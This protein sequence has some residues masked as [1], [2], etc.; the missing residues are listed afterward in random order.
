MTYAPR[1]HADEEIDL[2]PL[3]GSRLI[4]PKYP[5][6]PALLKPDGG[7]GLATPP[8]MKK[9]QTCLELSHIEPTARNRTGL[10]SLPF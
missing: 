2:S 1:G 10:I 5:I 9:A 4:V 3:I 8:S 6:E 7:A